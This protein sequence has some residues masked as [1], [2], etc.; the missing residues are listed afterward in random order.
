MISKRLGY[1]SASNFRS[2]RYTYALGSQIN[3]IQ[4][5]INSVKEWQI[6]EMS[7]YPVI[8]YFGY[9]H[10]K[11]YAIMLWI[12]DRMRTSPTHSACIAKKNNF[13]FGGRI[14]AIRQADTVFERGE[15]VENNKLD[16]VS[17]ET[18]YDALKSFYL[19]GA[20]N[21]IEGAKRLSSNYQASGNAYVQMYV[22]KIGSQTRV[23]LK[24]LDVTE[25][26]Y[27]LDRQ[28]PN[29]CDLVISPSFEFGYL[30]QFPPEIIPVSN[31]KETRWKQLDDNTKTTAFH[32]KHEAVGRKWYGESPTI[33]AVRH[34]Y[35]EFQDITYTTQ[36]SERG[37][38][39]LTLVEFE[40][41]EYTPPVEDDNGFAS[42]VGYEKYNDRPYSDYDSYSVGLGQPLDDFSKK[43][44]YQSVADVLGQTSHLKRHV[45]VTER[46]YGSKPMSTFHVPSNTNERYYATLAQLSK[47]AILQ[48]H[49]LNET[50]LNVQSKSSMGN[51]SFFTQFE[52]VNVTTIEPLQAVIE[53][54]IN[55]ILHLGL[56]EMGYTEFDNVS[57]KFTS[58]M[59][60]IYKERKQAQDEQST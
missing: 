44:H 47:D 9:G 30:E 34:M 56:R 33:A 15:T 8:P 51:D 21:L 11:S 59:Q 27:Y 57:I 26:M 22:T 58:A 2:N 20:D 18:F 48:V 24:F 13:A 43:Q 52:Y 7:T 12:L 25:G 41:D 5:E 60:K 31:H 3:P 37:Y 16:D 35:K 29:R 50:M 14:G 46:P 28:D 49:G 19:K 4:R 45:S 17:R 1:K 32:L 55:P 23:A 10:Y 6:S 40:A 54:F 36:E 42:A 53:N 39:G 38:A